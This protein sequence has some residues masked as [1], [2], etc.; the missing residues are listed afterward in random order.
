MN[1]LCLLENFDKELYG[2]FKNALSRQ[3]HSLSF[4]PDENATSPISASLMGDLLV[5]STENLI[6]NRSESLESLTCKRICELFGAQRANVRTVSI[7]AASRVVFQAL[8]SRGDVVMSLDLRKKEHCNSENLVYRFVNFGVDPST[9]V[10]DMDAVERQAKQNKPHLII[11]SPINY[12]LDIDY[13]RLSE[14]AKSCGAILWCDISQNA[15]LIAAG[16]MKS[17]VP[18]A[19][20]VTFSSHGSMQ[21][22]QAAVILSTNK[23]AN[24]IDRANQTSGHRGLMTQQLAALAM[25]MHEM[26]MPLHKEY[27]HAVIKNAKAFALGLT[28]GGMKIFCGEPQ[29]HLVMIDTRNCALSAR[30]AQGLLADLGIGVRICNMLTAYSDVKYEAVRFSTLPVTTR[31]LNE[32]SLIALGRNVGTFLQNPSDEKSKELDA[33]VKSLT[34]DLPIFNPKWLDS[35]CAKML[36]IA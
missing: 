14:I 36:N 30:G 23:I 25:R 8:A 7:E 33:L 20:V 28:E 18:F 4:I 29:S 10:L 22:P 19:D 31:G 15:S 24:V 34:E 16:A 2:F 13:E 9:Q 12:P 26:S 32:E 5:N 11:I 27:A 17:P 3:E 21:G 1:P 35:S 6:L